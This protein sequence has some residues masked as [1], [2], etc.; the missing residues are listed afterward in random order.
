MLSIYMILDTKIIKITQ[1]LLIIILCS[2]SLTR[3]SAQEKTENEYL[4]KKG[5]WA[6]GVDVISVLRSV[7]NAL[8][9]KN[10]TVDAIGGTPFTKGNGYFNSALMPDVSIAGKYLLTDNVALR[11]NLGLMI[12]SESAREY[13]S[14]DGSIITSITNE[15]KVVDQANINKN[16]M[17]LALGVEY[18][19]GSKRVQGVFGSGLLF[20]FQQDKKK[21]KWGNQ[22]TN[23]NQLPTINSVFDGYD[24]RGY[25]TLERFSAASTFYVGL[26]GSVGIEWFV[27]PK[28]SLGADVN[29]TA[30]YV[31]ESQQYRI[32]E[33]YNTILNNVEVRTDLINPGSRYFVFGTES[34]GGSLNM[35]FY[36]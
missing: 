31:F 25:R 27:V 16:G 14:D 20:A 4:P 17:S 26:T 22:M 29:L 35:T 1:R 6:V 21:Y 24:D 3:V 10:S 30:Y 28:I 18:R 19:K 15:A 13:T 33:G 32:S 9:G 7:G 34:L 36:F 12:R 23:I 2:L 11:A 8:G 5:D